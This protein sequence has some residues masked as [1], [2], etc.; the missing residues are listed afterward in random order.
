MTTFTN[1][2]TATAPVSFDSLL[3]KMLPRFRY[4]AKRVLRLKSD[5]Y[6]D[7]VQDMTAIAFDL[8][9]SLVRRGKPAYYSPIMRFA[10]KYYRIGRRFMGANTVDVLAER[11]QILG[12]CTVS[13]LSTFVN[14]NESEFMQDRRQVDVADDVQWRIDYETWLAKQTPKDQEII[15][16]LAMGE[17]LC[18]TARKAGVSHSCICQ[19][20]KR[21][22]ACWNDFI[23]DKNESA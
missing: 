8:Y 7:A 11:T 9:R 2:N 21:Y 5:N 12:R 4:F 13:S 17:T 20:R 3:E 19:Y 6:D 10:V 22:A 18:N 14:P 15:R 23:A 16:L 1:T